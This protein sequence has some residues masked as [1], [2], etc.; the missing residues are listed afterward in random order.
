MWI[1]HLI[2]LL[3]Y[4][5]PIPAFAKK[6]VKLEDHHIS[7]KKAALPI[8][9][10]IAGLFI[11]PYG[12]DGI[13][14]LFKQKEISDLG[15]LE[16]QSPALSSKYS[17]VML[18]SL[19]IFAFLYGKIKIHSS[20][21]F[22]F[23]G[24]SIMLVSNLRN[25]QMYAIGLIAVMCDLLCAI[26][27]PKA[28]K[29]LQ[30]T[31]RVLVALCALLT[32]VLIFASAVNLPYSFIFRDQPSDSVRVPVDA[33]EYLDAN[34]SKDS[35]IYTEFNGGAYV[36]WK[37]YKIYL[38]SRTEGYCKDVNGGY[39]LI[40]EYL[41]IYRNTSASCNET[42]SEFLSKYDFEYLIVAVNNKL[43]PYIS[44]REDYEP[45]VNGNG[46]VVFKAI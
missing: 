22:L 20:T 43:F 45:V 21:A 34:A 11:N 36:S 6:Y 15:I 17:I 4:L 27:L 38:C 41:S 26:P 28:E 10:M 44:T 18:V 39:D 16:L 42:F 32:A 40:G 31:N 13:T 9:C 35:R 24:T 23:L 3:P 37:G 46:Y 12:M 14:I 8:V 25:I 19:F 5:V 33:V 29:I 30:K 2:F 1:A 7:I